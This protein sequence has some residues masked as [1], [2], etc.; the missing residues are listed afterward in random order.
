MFINFSPQA[1]IVIFQLKMLFTCLYNMLL[2]INECNSAS[3]LS[4]T[5][6]IMIL[7]FV[8]SQIRFDIILFFTDAILI[9]Y[10]WHDALVYDIQI[11]FNI[12]MFY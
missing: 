12:F 3:T 10:P 7:T 8:F 6:F 1:I 4:L 5:L 11:L 9:L 2:F